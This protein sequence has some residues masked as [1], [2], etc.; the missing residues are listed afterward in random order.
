MKRNPGNAVEWQDAVDAAKF[1]LQIDS[2][3]QYGLVE[4]DIKLDHKR[5]EE[6]LQRGLKLGFR[7]GHIDRL[8]EK[9]LR[10]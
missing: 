1:L 8:I 4:T 2:A 5:C 3:R 6:I 7:P 10:D 9:F